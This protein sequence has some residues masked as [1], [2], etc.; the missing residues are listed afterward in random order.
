MTGTKSPSSPAC[1]TSCNDYSRY[2]HPVPVLTA[3]PTRGGAETTSPRGGDTHEALPHVWLPL[4]R[5]TLPLLR[6]RRLTERA[7]CNHF[8]TQMAASHWIGPDSVERPKREIPGQRTE[9]DECDPVGR[10]PA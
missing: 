1:V 7:G 3:P 5:T 4:R 6:L 8:A 10:C 9:A 2:T